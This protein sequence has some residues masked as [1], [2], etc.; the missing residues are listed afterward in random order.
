MAIHGNLPHRRSPACLHSASPPICRCSSACSVGSLASASRR[1]G[2]SGIW[3]A[4]LFWVATE[5][6]R[7]WLG[8][9]FPWVLLGSSQ[10]TVLP[11]AQLASVTG[12]YGL[13]ALVALVGTAAAA[14][15]LRRDRRTV[16]LASR[17]TAA[18]LV[19]DCDVGRVAAG[20]LRADGVRIADPRRTSAGQRAPGSRNRIR[21][22]G[23][24]SP[25]ATSRLSRQAIGAGAQLV[26]WP[27]ASTPFYFD[28]EVGDGRTGPPAGGAG[29]R[30]VR[31]RH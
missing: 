2:A 28:L 12:V 21:H 15:A 14:L 18:M 8:A 11:I 29:S 25:S 27:E 10:T 22:F 24:P 5:W 3:L 16:A 6:L 7:A 4:P 13:S 17:L 31:H 1:W 20:T 9:A 26:V 23:M 19:D 30:S